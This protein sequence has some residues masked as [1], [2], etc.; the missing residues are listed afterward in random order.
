MLNVL[1]PPIGSPNGRAAG[2]GDKKMC[3]S[4]SQ[5]PAPPRGKRPSAGQT[6]F[7]RAMLAAAEARDRQARD[8]SARLARI[9]LVIAAVFGWALVAVLA[10]SWTAP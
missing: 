4:P 9:D 1:A 8:W 6:Q 2:P 3:D 7:M 10:W 5:P